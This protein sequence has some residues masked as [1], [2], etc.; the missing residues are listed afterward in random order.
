[1][2]IMQSFL[3][4]DKNAF[5]INDYYVRNNTDRTYYYEGNVALPFFTHVVVSRILELTQYHIG[6]I[7]LTSVKLQASTNRIMSLRREFAGDFKYDRKLF[8]YHFEDD[9][10]F[11]TSPHDCSRTTDHNTST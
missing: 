1:M 5:K 11:T 10:L 9:A 3:I 6:T 7:I 4:I 8:Y 2:L